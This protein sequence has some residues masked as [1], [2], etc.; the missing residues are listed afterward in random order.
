MQLYLKLSEREKNTTG[1]SGEQINETLVV[2][3]NYGLL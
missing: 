1:I 3:N 2:M